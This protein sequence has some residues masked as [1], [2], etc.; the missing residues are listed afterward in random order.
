M[1][2]IWITTLKYEDTW[3]TIWPRKPVFVNNEWRRAARY[4]D[5]MLDR[6]TEVCRSHFERIFSVQ[7]PAKYRDILALEVTARE[8]P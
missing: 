2:K 7:A 6:G 5:N 1:P 8:L 3:L 4:R